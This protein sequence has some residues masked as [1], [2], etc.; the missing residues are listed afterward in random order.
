VRLLEAVALPDPER[1][2]RAYPHELSG[3]MKQ[4]VMIAIALSCKPDL[5]IADE[6]DDRARR[7]D[8]AQI[9]GLLRGLK[10]ELGLT[11]L[12]ITHDLGVV[13]ENADRVGVMYA[14]RL[15]EESPVALLFADAKH[16]YTKGLLTSMPEAPGRMPRSRGGA[17]S[18][19]GRGSRS[20]RAP[21]RLPLPSALCVSIRAL[22]DGVPGRTS[23]AASA[24]R[25]RATC[26]IPC[27][28]V[29]RCLEGT[30]LVEA[31]GLRKTFAQRTGLLG[32]R[33]A[34]ARAVDGVDLH[35]TPGRPGAGRGVR[36]R[37]VDHG[38]HADPPAGA[39]CRLD[40]LRRRRS[41]RPA[42]ARAAADA[43]QLPDRVPGSL[44]IAQPAHARRFHR[45]R[46]P[47]DPPDRGDAAPSGARRRS[48]SSSRSGSIAPPPIA[49]RTSSPADSAS[50][51]ASR[52]PSRARPRFL[53][54]DEPVSAL[55]P[56]VQAQIINLLVDLRAKLN[57]AYLFIAHDLRIVR[58][59]SDRVAVMYLGRIVEEA[60]SEEIYRRPLHPYTK[61]LLE[62][63]PRMEPGRATPPA[64]V[65]EPPSPIHP[66]R[67]AT[68]TPLSRSRSP[69]ARARI[70]RCAS[71]RPGGAP[72]AT[73]WRPP[74][75]FPWN[76]R[77][78][79]E[80]PERPSGV[81]PTATLVRMNGSCS[82]VG[83]PQEG[84]TI[85][86]RSPSRGRE[87]RGPRVRS[88]PVP[89]ESC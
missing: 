50:A 24:T 26:T 79:S 33:R 80:Y 71:W 38:T 85:R 87:N 22:R 60:P 57:L 14:G 7:H 49:T 46:A 73:S 59:V 43:A 70:R 31:R 23:P 27:T 66:P 1:Q 44:R 68:S 10:Q 58:H 48:A 42:R 37:Q 56:P 81:K 30:P 6:P 15:V 52:G 32:G 34:G 11:V 4:R 19:S 13:A 64:L 47:R 28:R 3:G 65:G 77:R 67:A 53:V 88:G 35:V 55:D 45:R 78:R 21:L 62:S 17:S 20:G 89:E 18:R 25:S 84:E 51:S 54:A 41:A 12:L 36:L 2:A 40:P 8:Q 86:H 83:S 76:P 16:P 61:A 29:R 74:P 72:P 82:V 69:C 5:L 75:T 39:R 9:L 63:T